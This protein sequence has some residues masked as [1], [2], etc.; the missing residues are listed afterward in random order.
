MSHWRSEAGRW[1]VQ[2]SW[3]LEMLQSTLGA[4]EIVLQNASR[5]KHTV[6][7]TITGMK[8]I[9]TQI[10]IRKVI[11]LQSKPQHKV[12][13][14]PRAVRVV[15][16][17]LFL[18][19]MMKLNIGIVSTIMR[20]IILI[21]DIKHCTEQRQKTWIWCFSMIPKKKKKRNPDRWWMK[22][23]C[24]LHS[25]PEDEPVPQREAMCAHV[26]QWSLVGTRW[27]IF[28]CNL[29][30]LW[31]VVRC[32]ESDWWMNHRQVGRRKVSS[33]CELNHAELIIIHHTQGLK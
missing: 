4:Y 30:V 23:S 21:R 12:S 3:D 33:A 19:Q 16:L 17:I 7:F 6:I 2:L 25:T 18:F 10:I 1:D 24:P 27:N 14:S 22:L 29:Y 9:H 31:S 8:D 15:R 28:S 13:I 11:P 32:G 26:W 5:Q 20:S